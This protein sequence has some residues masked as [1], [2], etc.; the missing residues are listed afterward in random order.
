MFRLLLTLVMAVLPAL[1]ACS[2]TIPSPESAG[3]TPTDTPVS[4]KEPTVT[5]AAAPTATPVQSP[6]LGP[7]PTPLPVV[8]VTTSTETRQEIQALFN[9]W[10]EALHNAD[11]TLL[12]STMAQELAQFC[13]PDKMQP[14]LDEIG[15][16]IPDFEL[17]SVFIDT[18]DPNQGMAQLQLATDEDN[19]AGLQAQAVSLFPIQGFPFP[20]KR[21]AGNWKAGFPLLQ[22]PGICPYHP[23][24]PPLPD[25]ESG[26]GFPSIPGLDFSSWYAP[27]PD[28]DH[29]PGSLDSFSSRGVA[30]SM[31]RAYAITASDFMKTDLGPA[32]LMNRYRENLTHPSW[33]IKDEGDS[34]EASWLTWTV[35]DEEGHLWYGTLVAA[36]AGEGWQ[37]VWLSLHSQELR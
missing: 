28:R 20:V 26:E 4:T 9:T 35:H 7:S 33:D 3:P 5:P 16:G 18:E 27:S 21:E 30:S 2:E 29:S 32:E 24:Q 13:D 19:G 25:P 23:S 15:P 37:R 12:H 22:G 14:W 6:A 17:V 8:Q 34:E 10:T 36:T 31:N 1:I 11:A